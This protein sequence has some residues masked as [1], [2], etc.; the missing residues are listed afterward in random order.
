M[1]SRDA[2]ALAP[3]HSGLSNPDRRA[4]EAALRHGRNG[5]MRFARRMMSCRHRDEIFGLRQKPPRTIRSCPR[6][7]V[8]AS[9]GLR[10][11]IGCRKV[12]RVERLD[13][14]A[15][16]GLLLSESSRPGRRQ[17]IAPL[18][19]VREAT[20]TKNKHKKT[21]KKPP[22]P[23]VKGFGPSGECIIARRD[24]ARLGSAAV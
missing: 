16:V 5:E 20:M 12:S 24:A 11:V 18:G 13:S 9:D 10:S 14:I 3:A 6:V 2:P 15:T 1:L 22:P 17:W 23:A 21:K 19:P 4:E 7:G 8:F